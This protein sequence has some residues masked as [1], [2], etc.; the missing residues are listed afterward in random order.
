MTQTVYPLVVNIDI[1]FCVVVL[2]HF[3][4]SNPTFMFSLNISLNVLWMG[5]TFFPENQTR[6]IINGQKIRVLLRVRAY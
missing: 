3:S 1:M 6:Q 5:T 2:K 4:A